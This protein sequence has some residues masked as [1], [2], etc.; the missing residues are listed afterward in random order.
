[1][2]K[3]RAPEQTNPGVADE[4]I[5][6]LHDERKNGKFENILRHH[7]IEFEITSAE[8]NKYVISVQESDYDDAKRVLLKYRERKTSAIR[9][10][11]MIRGITQSEEQ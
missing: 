5:M 2:G 1:M 7:E 3:P 11:A 9:Y 4:R 6:E 8:R 10:T